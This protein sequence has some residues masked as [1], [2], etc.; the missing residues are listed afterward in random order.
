MKHHLLKSVI[1]SLILVMGVSNAWAKR[2]YFEVPD[3][4]AWKG[5]DALYAVRLCK[6]AGI[7]TGTAW[8]RLTQWD[9]NTYYM[10]FKSNTYTH[11]QFCRMKDNITS[12]EGSSWMNLQHTSRYTMPSPIPTDND[13]PNLLVVGEPETYNNS[14]QSQPYSSNWDYQTFT[15]QNVHIVLEVGGNLWRYKSLSNKETKYLPVLLI[16]NKTSSQTFEVNEIEN[17]AT[18]F[19]YYIEG[20]IEYTGYTFIQPAEAEVTNDTPAPFQ[21]RSVW[22]DGLIDEYNKDYRDII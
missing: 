17:S 11:F 9:E 18:I 1:L 22:I 7:N 2:Y 14:Y 5:K 12:L 13:E 21:E 19:H 20:P 8:E 16:G 3:I 6:G 10:D 4:D 15:A